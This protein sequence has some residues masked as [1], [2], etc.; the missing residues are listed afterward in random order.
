MTQQRLFFTGMMTVLCALFL[1]TLRQRENAALH[2]SQLRQGEYA[3]VSGIGDRR[4]NIRHAPRLNDSPVLFRARPGDR[5]LLLNG[6]QF[7]DGYAWW[8]VRDERFDV[9]GWAAGKYLTMQD[10]ETES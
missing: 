2:T 10:S 3:I 4:L 1:L 6:P 7:I 5:L 9:A 8:R